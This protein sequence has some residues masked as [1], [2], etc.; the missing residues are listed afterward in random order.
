[1]LICNFEVAVTIV[2]NNAELSYLLVDVLDILGDLQLKPSW[3]FC[4]KLVYVKT[5]YL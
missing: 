1:M 3:S 5:L 4:T 2:F